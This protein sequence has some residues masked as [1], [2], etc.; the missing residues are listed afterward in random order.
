MSK[1][2]RDVLYLITEELQN[3]ENALRSCL[4][5]NK[6]WSEIIIPILWKNPWKY[7]KSGN[8]KL[9]LKVIIS[10]LSEK[11]KENLSIRFKHL[12]NSSYERPLFDYI[13]FC[14]HFNINE[15]ERIIKTVDKKS[16]IKIIKDEIYNLFINE[17]TKFT[18][19][20]IPY[21]FDR[22][23]HLI[24]GV[25]KCFSEIRFLSCNAKINLN[26]LPGLIEI[27]KSIRELELSIGASNN[28]YEIIRLIKT[29]K[30]LVKIRL[31]NEYY[32]ERSY[33][34]NL[35][36]TLAN[37]ADNILYLKLTKQPITN[38]VFSFVNLKVLVLN[39][40]YHRYT[41]WNVLK[42]LSLP[43][44]QILKT[45][46]IQHGILMNIIKN[47][48]GNL[49]ELKIDDFYPY[50]CDIG[51]IMH[52][53]SQSCPNLKYL[54]FPR[55]VDFLHL[56]KLLINCKDLMGLYFNFDNSY[57]NTYVHWDNFFETLAKSS[58]I[59]LFRFKF[60]LYEAPEL[61]SLK[62][63]FDNWKGRHPMLLQIIQDKDNLNFHAI[64]TMRRYYDLIEKSK[65][66]G[67]VKKYD[68][69]LNGITFK[70]FEWIQSK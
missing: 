59:N 18:H 24:P 37:H 21:Q 26:V 49:I 17:N 30:N 12:M 66:E 2:Y 6:T 10:H 7:L 45:S 35:E 32:S 60:Q 16:K 3:D 52:T 15:I 13:S 25:D 27:F 55:Y 5:V 41:N 62:L 44:L 57:L 1:L 14:K 4:L 28:K 23:L 61:K 29:S 34:K 48:G 67:I 20:Y 42:D 39:D 47:S 43:H 68:D 58:P 69:N 9:L 63:F 38:F 51:I 11:S 53:I 40:S 46:G 64:N 36:Q 65:A 56:E 54:K 33:C 22:Q 50:D 8:E 31:L 70:D 19:L